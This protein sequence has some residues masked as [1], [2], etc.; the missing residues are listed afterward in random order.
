MT[1]L[2]TLRDWLVALGV[3]ADPGPRPGCLKLT[4]TG[5]YASWPLLM[6]LDPDDGDLTLLVPGYLR[7]PA[8]AFAESQRAAL[9]HWLLACN[10][11]LALG[12]FELDPADGEVRFRLS[13]PWVDGSL[14]AATFRRCLE[15]A[16]YA[17]D[18]A[19]GPCQRLLWA[20]SAS[21]G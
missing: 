1:R 6:Y 9:A 11:E 2:D 17:C 7:V 4:L 3:H 15:A 20:E 19:W 12:G 5:Q 21:A 10:W 8:D 16:R 18:D 14:G 13:L